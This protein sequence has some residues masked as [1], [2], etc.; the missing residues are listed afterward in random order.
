MDFLS[1]AEAKAHRGSTEHQA[2]ALARRSGV[3]KD[4][5]MTKVCCNCYGVY[6][7]VTELKKH[8]A[9]EHPDMSYR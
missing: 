4:A 6:N 1:A 8:L 2:A 5:A 9:E 3:D 7:G